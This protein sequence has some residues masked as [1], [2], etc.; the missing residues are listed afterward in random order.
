MAASLMLACVPRPEHQVPSVVRAVAPGA[1]L[2]KWL[3]AFNDARASTYADFV[4][5]HMPTLVPYLDDDLGL[6]E[7]TGG[8]T[9][10][11]H[12]E[13]APGQITAWVRDRNW[14][15]F[16]RVVLSIGDGRIDD[17]SFQG[18]PPPGDFAIRRLGEHEALTLLH[19]RLREEATAGRFSGAVLVAKDGIVLFREAYGATPATR[20]CIGSMGKMFTA[21]AVLQLVQDGRLG[22]TDTLASLLPAYPDTALARQV[23]VQHLLTHTGGTGDFFGADYDAHAAQLR[24]PSDFIRHFGAREVAFPPGS[25]WGYSNFGFILLGAIV[26]QVSGLGWD[27]YLERNVFRTAGMSSTSPVASAGNT[28]VPCTGATQPGLK[29]LPFYVGLPAGGG[30]S[31]LDDLHRFGTVLSETRLLDARHLELLTTAN[32]QAGN[33]QWSLGLRVAVRNGEAYYGHGGSAPG[34]NADF[35]IYPRSGYE[36]IVLANRGHPHAL[37]VADFIGAR[38]PLADR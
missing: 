24:T 5:A 17:L 8:F 34:V 38:L 16:S 19:Q 31:T 25:R 29:P 36:V 7:A 32:V 20:F 15:R 37:N 10:L 27:V 21:V 33:S 3:A 28:A 18:A 23:T 12:E 11:R 6:R 9:L 35:A 22:L 14:D 26:E 13:T 2:E 4:R 30:Y 1:W